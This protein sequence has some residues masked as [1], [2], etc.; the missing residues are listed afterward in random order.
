MMNEL[1]SLRFSFC[2]F[3]PFLSKADAKEYFLR[4]DPGHI[5]QWTQRLFIVTCAFV[6]PSEMTFRCFPICKGVRGR[7][8][9][10]PIPW[11]SGTAVRISR[12]G[13]RL[14]SQ[15]EQAEIMW[16]AREWRRERLRARVERCLFL[17]L[18]SILCYW[19]RCC[20]CSSGLKWSRKTTLI[21]LHRAKGVCSDSG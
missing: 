13:L 11:C 3:F 17:S 5:V 9:C 21:R 12:D 19:L 15:W 10:L 8:W 20:F 18:R 1:N 16:E 6:H 2:S 14:M 7:T 4:L